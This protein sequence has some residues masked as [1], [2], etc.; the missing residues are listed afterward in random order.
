MFHQVAL[1]LVRHMCRQLLARAARGRL[2]PD[3]FGAATVRRVQRPLPLGWLTVALTLAAALAAPVLIL[4]SYRCGPRIGR[5]DV[6]PGLRF[7]LGAVGGGS[8]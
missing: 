7:F 1:P 8:G 6:G 4:W 2:D 3:H 5:D